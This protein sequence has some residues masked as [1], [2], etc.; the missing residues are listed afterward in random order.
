M[1]ATE[2]APETTEQGAPDRHLL[3]IVRPPGESARMTIDGSPRKIV[4]ISVQKY[5][6]GVIEVLYEGGP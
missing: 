5:G 3:R 6:D 2:T 1:T 4:R